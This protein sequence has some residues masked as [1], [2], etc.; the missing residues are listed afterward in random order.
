MAW[1]GYHYVANISRRLSFCVSLLSVLTFHQEIMSV[2][3]FFF[4]FFFLLEKLGFTGVYMYLIF[5]FFLS[6]AHI[7][8]TR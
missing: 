5:L 2:N 8:G 4:F 6:K 7:V 3:F 1:V